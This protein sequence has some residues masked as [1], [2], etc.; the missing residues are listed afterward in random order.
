MK[1]RRL[2]TAFLTLLLVLS[3]LSFA[4]PSAKAEREW[5][6]G[7]LSWNLS[8]DGTLTITAMNPNAWNNYMNDF[9]SENPAP[10]QVDDQGNDIRH[11]VKKLVIG[12][13]VRNCGEYAFDRCKNLTTV[14]M[15][16]DSV[17]LIA[18][19]ALRDCTKLKTIRL[20]E[21]LEEIHYEAFRGCSGLTSVT[22]PAS[23]QQ[24]EDAAFA[25]CGLTSVNVPEGTAV[26]TWDFFYPRDTY[27]L[28]LYHI[29]LPANV[30]NVYNGA[31]AYN[32]LPYDTPECI[33]PQGTTVISAETFAGAGVRYVWLSED[34]TRIGSGAFA[35][36]NLQF[37]YI[38]WG[39]Q[40][41]GDNALPEGTAVLTLGAS[42]Q[43]KEYVRTHG[44]KLLELEDPE[45]GNG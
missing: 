25:H 5:T 35:G 24:I 37:I 13:G 11:K 43:L 19:C 36:S 38:P 29:S 3:S 22:L 30:R 2:V 14:E 9:D 27:S 7:N 23:L 34:S 1:I 18:M 45:A 10:W 41:F 44:L 28:F 15:A 21:N 39:C 26:K 32:P 40:E 31:F 33:L 16:A 8:E 42:D 20:S 4:S 12:T 6:P 17:K